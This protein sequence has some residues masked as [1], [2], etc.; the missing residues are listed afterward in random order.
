MFAQVG[1]L[2]GMA[3][4]WLGR[5]GPDGAV[6]V[7]VRPV[8][9]RGGAVARVG[10]VAARVGAVTLGS[11][12]AARNR[13]RVASGSGRMGSGPAMVDWGPK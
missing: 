12:V 3:A 7:Q 6:A 10:P 11:V 2:A 8:A 13:S 9:A 1:S 5:G 4:A